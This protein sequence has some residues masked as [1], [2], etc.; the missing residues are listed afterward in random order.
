MNAKII[1]L[2]VAVILMAAPNSSNA[3]VKKQVADLSG[4]ELAELG[5][6]LDQM[7]QLLKALEEAFGVLPSTKRS[8][9]KR[10]AVDEFGMTD[11]DWE[12]LVEALEQLEKMAKDMEGLFAGMQ[13]RRR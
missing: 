5:A 10:E 7:D 13:R 12:A 2:G 4:D 3:F 1:L 6:A 8:L 11:G 9:T